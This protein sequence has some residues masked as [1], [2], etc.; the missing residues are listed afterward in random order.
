MSDPDTA[1]P[2]FRSE[3]LRAAFQGGENIAQTLIGGGLTIYQGAHPAVFAA[4][5]GSLTA[6]SYFKMAATDKRL[7]AAHQREMKQ[8]HLNAI[9][10]R[11]SP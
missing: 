4:V 6:Y 11:G 8:A 2:S 7:E 9:M 1:Q 5:V 3:W 10:G